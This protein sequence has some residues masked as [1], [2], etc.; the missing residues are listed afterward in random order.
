MAVDAN[1]LLDEHRERMANLRLAWDKPA[2]EQERW[3]ASFV[4]WVRGTRP[5]S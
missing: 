4:E 5:R 2:L 1:H 3:W